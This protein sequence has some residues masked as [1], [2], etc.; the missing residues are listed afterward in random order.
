MATPILAGP[1]ESVSGF[2]PFHNTTSADTVITQVEITDE[3]GTP[4]LLAVD[5]VTVAA[6]TTARIAITLSLQ[7]QT[8]PGD[9]ALTAAISNVTTEISAQVAESRQ[10]A[11]S[12]DAVVVD[13]IPE[14]VF[15]KPLV[16]SNMGNVAVHVADFGEVPLY[17]EDT[18]L[19]TILAISRPAPD[20]T[21]R[22]IDPLPETSVSLTVSTG[23]GRVEIPAG[24]SRKVDLII[25]VP[26]DLPQTARY[27]ALLP[28][29]VRSLVL[30]VVP[31]GPESEAP[32]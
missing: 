14:A 4:A 25:T 32:Q 16:V 21:P 7:P 3:D 5:P 11:I 31:A 23:T 22:T 30:A 15:V 8:A 6:G 17:R 20:A 28:I 18:A 2:V 29:S 10:L 1:P 13:N 26:A 12:P 24:E 19:A 9:Y 27:L